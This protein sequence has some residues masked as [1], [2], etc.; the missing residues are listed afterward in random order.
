MDDLT[1]EWYSEQ[2]KFYDALEAALI[3]K[4]ILFDAPLWKGAE[5]V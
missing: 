5:A 1:V 2:P 4:N 3:D